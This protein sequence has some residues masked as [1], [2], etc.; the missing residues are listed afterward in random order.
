MSSEIVDNGVTDED[1]DE[2]QDEEIDDGELNE[3]A[4]ESEGCAIV[5]DGDASDQ[6]DTENNDAD[7][8]VGGDEEHDESVDSENEKGKKR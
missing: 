7:S 3:S 2:I 8:D 5:S 4:A 6:Y 1:I